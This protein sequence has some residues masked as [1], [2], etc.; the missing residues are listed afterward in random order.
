VVG[1]GAGQLCTELVSD[2]L[3]VREDSHRVAGTEPADGLPGRG[4]R[5]CEHE[6]KSAVTERDRWSK[7]RRSPSN[8]EITVERAK[9]NQNR[10]RLTVIK[11]V[12]HR[13]ARQE[14]P[15]PEPLHRDQGGRSPW[16]RD[17]RIEP[18]TH[19]G[20]QRPPVRHVQGARPT[21]SRGV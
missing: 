11:A 17:R 12:D 16:S 18:V 2:S 4:W 5:R 1:L 13:G 10:N 21:A 9:G 14:Q 3:D 20:D 15:K 6:L 7:A 8:A 19:H